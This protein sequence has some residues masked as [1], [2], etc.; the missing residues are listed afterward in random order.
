MTWLSWGTCLLHGSV[1]SSK[2][3]CLCAKNQPWIT[4]AELQTKLVKTVFPLSNFIALILRN[5]F[6]R[7]RGMPPRPSLP[8]SRSASTNTP[9]SCLFALKIISPGPVFWAAWRFWEVWRVL[10]DFHVF[11]IGSVFSYINTDGKSFLIFQH[12]PV[13]NWY[14]LSTS[15]R[16]SS[17]LLKLHKY[18]YTLI[19]L[20]GKCIITKLKTGLFVCAHEKLTF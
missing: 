12:R 20:T 19:Y 13:R 17:L 16:Y 15:S 11:H 10:A 8:S 4:P 2:T 1:T 5:T 9:K 6:S 18:M 14:W 7:G 3:P